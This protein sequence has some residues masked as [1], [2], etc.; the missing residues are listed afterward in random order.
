M[1]ECIVG[2]NYGMMIRRIFFLAIV[3]LFAAC[4]R[5]VTPSGGAVDK[6]PPKEIKSIPKQNSLNFKDKGFVVEFDEYI[7]L[8]NVNQKLLVSPPLKVKP[9]ITAKLKKLYVKGLDSLTEN[10]TYIFDFADAITDFNEGNRLKNFKYAFSTGSQIDSLFYEG[11]VLEGFSL[12]N[13]AD[14]LVLLYADTVLA[15]LYDKD[16]NYITRTDSSGHFSFSNLAAGTYRLLVLD[17]KNQNKRY[18]LPSEGV[19]FSRYG[20]IPYHKDST[21]TVS[22]KENIFFY[23]DVKDSIQSVIDTRFSAKGVFTLVFARP[24]NKDFT[25]DFIKPANIEQIKYEL[26]ENRDTV[27]FFAGMGVNFDTIDLHIADGDFKDEITKFAVAGKKKKAEESCFRFRNLQKDSVHYFDRKFLTAGMPLDTESIPASIV[28]GNDTLETVLKRCEGLTKYCLSEDLEKGRQYKLIIDS[29][30]VRDLTGISNDFFETT[31]YLTQEADYGRFMLNFED[32]AFVDRPHI[33]YLCDMKA[34]I[35]KQINVSEGKGSI[36]FD[37]IRQGIYKVKLV[38]D[39]N[40]NGQWDGAS[41]KEGKPSER[42]L[43]FD[44]PVSIRKSWDTEENWT[45]SW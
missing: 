3:L 24:L 30:V 39:E 15:N 1:A 41:F 26:S 21:D 23:E 10:T 37:R 22:R 19:G 40:A 17:D 9:E 16:C 34:E 8:D 20:V 6:V 4:A 33:F 12:K 29:G 32:S 42:I 13:I 25:F 45:I 14:K 11:R 5:I 7:V 27:S 43:M 28:S 44:K 38:L 35:L 18:D 2:L 36:V 31:F